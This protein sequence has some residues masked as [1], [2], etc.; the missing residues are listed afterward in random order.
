MTSY[1]CYKVDSKTW[2]KDLSPTDLGM[3]D[4]LAPLT[5][6]YPEARL[7]MEEWRTLAPSVLVEVRELLPDGITPGAS[8]LHYNVW[9]NDGYMRWTNDPINA[10][11]DRPTPLSYLDAYKLYNELYAFNRDI[12]EIGA[13]WKPQDIYITIPVG[14]PPI[15]PQPTIIIDEKHTTPEFSFE[16]YNGFQEPSVP[17]DYFGRPLAVPTDPYTGMPL[18]HPD[19][20]KGR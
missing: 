17:R 16:V 18:D 9:L 3:Q 6:S 5:L 2:V 14:D 7:I 11:T 10:S 19:K 1:N 15:A 12:K 13:D 8:A 4:P 20:D